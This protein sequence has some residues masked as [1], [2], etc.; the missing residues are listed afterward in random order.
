MSD[1][2]SHGAGG[3]GDR[4]VF[5]KTVPFGA[6]LLMACSGLGFLAVPWKLLVAADRPTTFPTLWLSA[7]SVGAVVFAGVLVF[8]AVVG[9]GATT[10]IDFGSATFESVMTGGFGF[11]RAFTAKLVDLERIDVESFSLQSTDTTSWRVLIRF[12]GDRGAREVRSFADVR[13]AEVFADELRTRIRNR[14]VG[15]P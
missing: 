13:S 3:S 1:A 14:L 2:G 5:S 4:M 7:L 6:R 8:G 10:T 12:R 11:R 15:G 9:P